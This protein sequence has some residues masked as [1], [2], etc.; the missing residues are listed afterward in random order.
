MCD[1]ILAV[2]VSFLCPVHPGEGES[3]M[4]LCTHTPGY[5]APLPLPL[6]QP[7]LLSPF[8]P[9]P[10]PISMSPAS[11]DGAHHPPPS[12]RPHFCP[13]QSPPPTWGHVTSP[14]CRGDHILSHHNDRTAFYVLMDH[15][16]PLCL[17]MAAHSATMRRR[18]RTSGE[19]RGKGNC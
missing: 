11:T 19:G 17:I 2:C 13:S 3:S 9:P 6:P 18:G 16:H 8:T 7:A 5:T 10:P 4:L 15:L 1:D 12:I 14:R